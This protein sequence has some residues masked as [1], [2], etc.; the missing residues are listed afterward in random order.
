MWPVKQIAMAR[1]ILINFFKLRYFLQNITLVKKNFS[2]KLQA[3][4][5]RLFF[6]ESFKPITELPV[7]VYQMFCFGTDGGTAATGTSGLRYNKGLSRLCIEH[8]YNFPGFF[9]GHLHLFSR[10]VDRARLIDPL[11]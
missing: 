2:C 4:F 6:Q 5:L 10:L 9:I 11:Q 7:P 8:V 3:E 1:Q